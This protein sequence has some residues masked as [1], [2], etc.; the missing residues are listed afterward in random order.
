MTPHKPISNIS[1]P[2]QGQNG[3]ALLLTLLFVG[4]IGAAVMFYYKGTSRQDRYQI[5]YTLG[6]QYAMVARASHV[7]VQEHAYF[8]PYVN[9]ADNNDVNRY[10]YFMNLKDSVIATFREPLGFQ[11]NPALNVVTLENMRRPIKHFNFLDVG[12][13]LTRPMRGISYTFRAHGGLVPMGLSPSV[14]AASA[15]LVMYGRPSGMNADIRTAADM[16]A[17]RAGAAAN[18]LERVGIVLPASQ[19]ARLQC[20]GQDAIVKWGNN[21]N[22]CLSSAEASNIGM[23]L[24]TFDVVAP[25]W[26]SVEKHL[27]KTSMYRRPHPGLSGTNI[28]NIDL[29]MSATDHAPGG[30]GI[31]DANEIYTQ[32]VHQESVSAAETFLHIGAIDPDTHEPIA[33]LDQDATL[34]VGYM[35]DYGMTS[36]PICSTQGVRSCIS[37]EVDITGQVAV[38]YVPRGL[39][40]P[41]IDGSIDPV[42]APD[43]MQVAGAVIVSNGHVVVQADKDVYPDRGFFNVKGGSGTSTFNIN[44]QDGNSD[45]GT[46]IN[47]KVTLKS[48]NLNDSSQ[49]E[50]FIVDK[51]LVITGGDIEIGT[52]ARPAQLAFTDS[53]TVVQGIDGN[54]IS[55]D[56]TGKGS[57]NGL[58][59]TRLTSE[60]FEQS[61]NNAMEFSNLHFGDST[62]GDKQRVSVKRN[63]SVDPKV[64]YPDYDCV[65]RA[66]PDQVSTGPEGTP[67]P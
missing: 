42:P 16:A 57:D 12:L 40:P 50:H 65:G 54:P 19:R 18:G 28:M 27:N 17:F 21:D 58:Y 2:H 37:G 44:K 9:T 15:L 36:E 48:M 1:V 26:E 51:E 59:S 46:V 62:S 64:L 39:N 4:I 6:E 34:T 66:C 29:D 10:N 13:T 63:V 23:N 24:D 52:T 20:R 38:S 47:E 8:S 22:D 67:F 11:D 55:I 41:E 7:Y 31:K 53:T 33:T 43:V 32:T 5:Y 56:T 61:G 45:T 3:F 14:Q 49:S 35:N 60:N 25:A 30:R